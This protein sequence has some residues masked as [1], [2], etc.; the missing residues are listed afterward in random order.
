M[1]NQDDIDLLFVLS[2]HGWSVCSL[3]VGG[4]IHEVLISH[5]FS[6]PLSDL[7]ESTSAL[8]KGAETA[9]FTWWSEPAGTQWQ[10][11]RNLDER[12]K[13]SVTI[14]DLLSD[15]G[16]PVIYGKVIVK[17]E[18]KIS[19]F[20]TIVYYQMKKLETLLREKSFEKDRSGEFP[21]GA[22][23]RLEGCLGDRL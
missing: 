23:R 13:V 7:I 12:H 1:Y 9:E 21:Y 22:F 11:A 2:Y 20:S 15:Y 3:Y 4:Q 18:I 8:L 6:D 5:T 14:A 16:R 19:Q 17:F 10:F